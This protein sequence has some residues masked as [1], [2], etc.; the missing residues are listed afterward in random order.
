[1]DTL[2]RTRVPSRLRRLAH[3]AL[4]VFTYPRSVADW[5][6]PALPL[7]SS[8]AR[9]RVV[10][11]R[12]ETHDVTTLVLEPNG[13]WRGH[14]A[15]QWVALDCEVEGIVK[16]RCFS[17]ASSPRRHDGRI[18]ITVKARSGGAVTPHLV[19][20][21][22]QGAIVGL[23]R[24]RGDFVLPDPMPARLLFVSGGSGITPLMSMLRS[25]VG[26][27]PSS[28][29]PAPRLVFIHFARS[30][31][32]VVFGAELAHIAATTTV[33]VE[34]FTGDHR[35]GESGLA[36]VLA[37]FETHEAFVCGPEPLIEAVTSAYTARRAGHR[38][39]FERFAPSAPTRR[40]GGNASVTFVESGRRVEGSRNLLAMAE[41]AG[42]RPES[43]CRMGICHTC[44]RRKVSGTT[45]DLRSG[46]LSTDADVDV[47]LCV[48]MPVGAV[49]I[50]L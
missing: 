27:P 18:E 1:M 13:Q 3:S 39:H 4:S 16:T 43:G 5:I 7:A 9:A 10:D 50:D 40:D 23:S 21:T 22:K 25:I 35:L 14:R 24:A 15:G 45:R 29:G 19:E 8:R 30:E 44:V 32:D 49:E 34:I 28:I 6:E 11:V 33:R 26:A 42:L 36:N 37:D 2:E 31:T 46:A 12:R 47:Q 20:R 48:S 41:E 38:V 17:I